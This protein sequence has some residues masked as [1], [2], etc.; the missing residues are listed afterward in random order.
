M[1]KN[2]LIALI[3]IVVDLVG[4]LV[5]GGLRSSKN[6]PQLEALAQCLNSKGA[7]MY[8]TNW[9]SWCQKEEAN[10]K[11]TWRFINYIDCSKNPKDCLALGIEA[12]PTWIFPDGKRLTGYQGLE[13]LAEE[14]GCKLTID[15]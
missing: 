14:S 5:W 4:L 3:I 10:F 15:R 2:I 12:T 11:D 13:K 8:G 1:T 6:N 7:V 9:C